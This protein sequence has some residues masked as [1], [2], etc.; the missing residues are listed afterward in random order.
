VRIERDRVGAFDAPKQRLQAFGQTGDGSVRTIDVEPGP[1]ARGNLGDLIERV[2]GSRRRRAC[3]RH[4][5]GRHHALLRV[6]FEGTLERG[7]PH[8]TGLVDRDLPE[9]ADTHA[10]DV[11]GPVDHHVGLLGSVDGHRHSR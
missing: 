7:D 11:H 9:A 6:L 3:R 5:R 4:D 2:D 10:E 1:V 8:A